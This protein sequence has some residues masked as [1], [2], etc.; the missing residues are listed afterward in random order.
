MRRSYSDCNTPTARDKQIIKDFTKEGV[1]LKDSGITDPD[2]HLSEVLAPPIKHDH[3]SEDTIFRLTDTRKVPTTAIMH[4][5]PEE[6]GLF[7]LHRFNQRKP[8]D[9]KVKSKPSRVV[10]TLEVPRIAMAA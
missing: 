8:P 6:V 5:L 9:W 10:E 4:L 1:P 3:R 2:V 7:P